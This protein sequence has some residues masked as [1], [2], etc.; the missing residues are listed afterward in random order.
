VVVILLIKIKQEFQPPPVLP[1]VTN[2]DALIMEFRSICGRSVNYL[3]VVLPFAPV[4]SIGIGRENG[5][6]KNDDQK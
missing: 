3:G 2:M 6:K 4:V 5:L 1:A